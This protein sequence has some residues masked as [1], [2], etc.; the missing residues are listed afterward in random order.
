MKITVFGGSGFLGSHL[1]DVLSEAGHETTVFD[2]KPSPWLRP[3]QKMIVGDILD[4]TQV[5]KALKNTEIVYNFAGISDLEAAAE[6]PIATVRYNILG[7]THLL[8]AS[9]KAG[10]R[11]FIFASSLYVYSD[12][13][14]FYRCGKAAAEL[15]VET[16]HRQYGLD[17]T[18]LR[19]GSLYG[20]RA[21]T[22]NGLYRILRQAI[23]T[24]RIDYRGKKDALREYI[25]VEDAA[26]CSLEILRPQY[27]NTHV[28]L[29]GQ[30][31]LA[32]S[33]V[34]R[35]IEEILG[36]PIECQ[37]LEEDPGIHYSITPYSFRPHPAKRISP[38]QTTDLG[39]GILHL[40]AEIHD[41]LYARKQREIPGEII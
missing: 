15:Y 34:F 17:Y 2:L 41:D 27:A 1:A 21:D 5:E 24:G 14:G 7:N 31:S 33:D 22:R 39:Q 6:D 3:D 25:H 35:M 29:T 9:R 26:R 37:Y 23:E 11:R 8:E 10:I 20:P 18:I 40:A 36:H 13:G 16:Y 12:G 19:Y 28:I 32:V 4:L 38:R 30:Q